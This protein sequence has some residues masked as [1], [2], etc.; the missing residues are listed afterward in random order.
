MTE[1]SV[2]TLDVRD[3]APRDRHPTI[4]ARLD[5]SNRAIACAWSTIMIRPHCGTSCSASARICS[6]GSQ[7]SERHQPASR[8]TR[9]AG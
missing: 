8:G 5:A 2:V 1:I 9:E 3:M 4:F 6:P 7:S